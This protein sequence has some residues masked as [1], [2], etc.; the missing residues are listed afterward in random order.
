MAGPTTLRQ[1]NATFS[2]VSGAFRMI[3]ATAS[4]ITWRTGSM[5]GSYDRQLPTPN[6]QLPTPTKLAELIGSWGLEVGS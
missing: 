6:S 5:V 1:A 4:G 2:G 3:S